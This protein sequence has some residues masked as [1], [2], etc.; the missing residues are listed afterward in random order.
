M[1]P[2]TSASIPGI[3]AHSCAGLAGLEPASSS[4]SAAQAQDAPAALAL[5]QCQNLFKRRLARPLLDLFQQLTGLRLYLWWHEPAAPLSQHA[6]VQL[7]PQARRTRA[8]GLRPTCQDCLPRRWVIEWPNHQSEK[9][10]PCTFGLTNY[11]AC[12]RLPE[13]PVL[14]LVVQRPTP[15]SHAAKQAFSQ[16]IGLIRLIVHDLEKT[17]EAGQLAVELESLHKTSAAA[18]F[19]RDAAGPGGPK[20]ALSSRRCKETSN[21]KPEVG[22]QRPG[23]DRIRQT[24]SRRGRLG[25]ASSEGRSGVT[26][27]GTHPLNGN[28]R[29]QLVQR[30]LDYIHQH[31]S[32]SVELH[33]LAASMNLNGSYVSSLFS[34][35]LGVTFHHYLEEFRLARAKDL[36]RDSV[37]RVSEVA[38]AVGYS[39]P[40]HFRNVFTT[41][42]GLPPSA[43]R[44]NQT[45]LTRSPR[46]A[47]I[48]APG[49]AQKEHYDPIFM[50]SPDNSYSRAPSH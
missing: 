1:N 41:R 30:M 2:A 40:N 34:T 5:E 16:A 7:C 28:H 36:L 29:Q 48:R 47:G 25:G 46:P 37:K 23:A 45:P 39:N 49:L 35:T 50:R 32:H 21:Q 13:R 6:L 19:S 10:F 17:L 20:T 44:R 8:T 12:L 18:A 42:V 31:Y 14:T 4:C 11:F 33:D 38:Y 3:G 15:T 43:W 27:S 24:S 9:R 22:G 26:E